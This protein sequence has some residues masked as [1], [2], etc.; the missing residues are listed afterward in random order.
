M[1]SVHPPKKRDYSAKTCIDT[2]QSLQV[3]Y[4]KHRFGV[5]EEELHD[6]V[7]AAGGSAMKVEA[8]LKSK[9]ALAS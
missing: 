1:G 6:A 8:Y 7:Q 2:N 9:D 4:W 5:S 3:A